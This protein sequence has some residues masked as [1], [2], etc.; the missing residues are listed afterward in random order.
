MLITLLP[1]SNVRPRVRQQGKSHE[2]Q[3][4]YFRTPRNRSSDSTIYAIFLRLPYT[5]PNFA[6][7]WTVL[8]IT[9]IIRYIMMN[10]WAS[11]ENLTPIIFFFLLGAGARV[12]RR[13]KEQDERCRADNGKILQVLGGG[14]RWLERRKSGDR[15]K[16]WGQ[17]AREDDHSS[18]T[19]QSI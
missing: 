15:R 10:L 9:K 14:W 17:R 6:I 1:R 19:A 16:K 11:K 2:C 5:L 18:S 7:S 3:S 13:R 4:P 12:L 8:G